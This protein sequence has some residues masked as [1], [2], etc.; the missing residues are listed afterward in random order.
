MQQP[1]ALGLAI[2]LL[3]PAA[4]R[5]DDQHVTSRITEVT[6]QLDRALVVRDAQPVLQAGRHTLV[7]NDLPVALDLRTVRLSSSSAGV[8]IGRPTF[9]EVET[10]EP[11]A[12]AARHL[13]KLL[14]QLQ[15]QRRIERD[16]IAVQQLIL[17]VLRRSQIGVEPGNGAA[18]GDASGLFGLIET[19]SKEALQAIRTAEQRIDQLD[20]EIDRHERE[21]ARLGE[22]PMRRLELSLPITAETAGPAALQLSYA[23]RGA[24][25]APSVEARLDVAA[26][27][28]ELVA[29]AEVSQRSGEDWTGVELALSTA[30]P[31]W[32]TAAPETDTWYIDV[33]RDEPHAVARLEAASPMA[34]MADIAL[35]DIDLDDRAFDVV[36]RLAEPQ[37]ITADGSRHEVRLAVETLPAELVWRSVPA[38]DQRAY[39]TAAT[40]YA[41]TTPLLPGPVFLYRDGQAIGQT[42]HAG[43]QPGEGLEL[44]FGADPAIAIERRLL[45]DRRA[46]SGL[47]GTTRRHERRYAID[48][49]NRRSRP[50]MLEIIDNL[51]VSRDSRI[52]V[53]LDPATTAPATTEHGGAA[54]VLA[55]PLEL[56]PD[57][58]TTITFA[59]TIRHP[60]DLDVTG[61]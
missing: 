50:V 32:Q 40:I 13:T 9:R 25:F 39:L 61:F 7:F 49:T 45:T 36:Y 57:A 18:R 46:R 5:A 48:A 55:W 20:A 47:V 52:T 6:V 42:H 16:N 12:P 3:L 22:D 8:M 26:G 31:S 37:T 51:P 19:R 29:T 27:R 38:L 60:A 23:V 10:T 54:G 11:V 44:G 34:A 58:A 56:A 41:G 33:R 28:I 2:C 14:D 59:Y 1:L 53:E 30:T 17:D 15:R 21:L 43:L 35:D 4:G 24:G